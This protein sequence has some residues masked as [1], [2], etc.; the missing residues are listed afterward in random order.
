[1]GFSTITKFQIVI[2]Y[3]FSKSFWFIVIFEKFVFHPKII[4]RC[5]YSFPQCFL[6]TISQTHR[7]LRKDFS[8]NLNQLTLSYIKFLAIFVFILKILFTLLAYTHSIRI[9]KYKKKNNEIS[10]FI[11]LLN[12]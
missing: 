9:M 1:M 5:I 6:L 4:Q 11:R 10:I 8:I 12:I 2:S 7:I 3:S